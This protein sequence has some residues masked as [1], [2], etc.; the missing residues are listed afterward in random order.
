MT[1]YFGLKLVDL[2]MIAAYF[3]VVMAIGFWSSRKVKTESDFFLGG[4]RFGKGLLVMHWLCT[5]TH[6]EM[7]VQVAGATARVGLGGIWYQ[8]MWLF[9]TP[10]YWLMAPVTRR[11][12]VTTTGD[13]FRIRYGRSLEMLYAVVGLFY[14]SLSI[15]LLLRGAGAAIS[16]ATGGAVPTEASVIALA[17]LFSTYVM[18]GGLVA[19]VYTD[20]LQGLMIIVLSLMLVPA[21]LSVVGGLSGL[22]DRLGP[23]MFA[24]T[25][26]P[27]ARE[28][29]PWF[30]VT[31]S[32]LGL[33]GFVVQPHVM[34]AT[35][36]GKTETEARVGMVY[37]N[38]IKRV[39]TIAWAFTGLIAVAAFPA[40]IAGLDANGPQAR[41][42]SETLFGRAIQSFLGDGWRGLMIACLI[43]GVTSAET[44][45]VGGSALFTRNFYVH[46]VPGRSDTHYLWV[47]RLAAGGLLALGI[48]LAVR[49]ESVTQLVLGS[50]KLIGLLGAAFWLGVVWR[51]ATAAAVWA[52]FLS[53]LLVWAVMSAEPPNTA[54][55]VVGL[56]P[57]AILGAAGSLGLRG[58]NEPLQV[59]IM[60]AVEFGLMILVSLVTRP[61]NLSTLDPFYARLH[62][63]VGKEDEVR[64]D[65][66]H[67]DLPE[68][69]TLGM[70]GITLDYRKS[71]RF[72]YPA[73]Q[74]LGLEI[75]RMTRFDWG[76]F[77]AAWA[78]VGGLIGLLIW[79][80]ALRT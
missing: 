48:L 43:A 15:A 6:S 58:L 52:S 77:L 75:P 78:L 49:A 25:T 60:L 45:M 7:A 50:V 23:A 31:M 40:V 79:L 70:E 69:A 59:I 41:H 21:G 55:P 51:R 10:F 28:G 61:R 29:D 67:D 54:I 24:I 65:E 66:P 12:R 44:F 74:K 26:P 56:A 20:L 68:S 33:V 38:F 34:T 13:Y 17:V 9:S 14:F 47:G 46:A 76:G 36:S 27:G 4:R 19:A 39:L 53:S 62:T 80:A 2:A 32:A 16:G 37:G 22:H 63:P 1:T 30:V 57:R 11:L 5:G 73:L 71:S 18:A 72:A 42:A 64:W 35:G 8:W 3:V